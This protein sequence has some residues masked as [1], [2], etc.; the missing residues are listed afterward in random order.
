M[1]DTGCP[2]PRPPAI[3]ARQATPNPAV[4]RPVLRVQPQARPAKPRP[5]MRT[6]AC[7]LPVAK[8]GLQPALPALL[9]AEVPPLLEAFP[10]PWLA[11]AA[12]QEPLAFDPPGAGPAEARTFTAQS[13]APAPD[14]TPLIPTGGIAPWGGVLVPAPVPGIPEPSTWL[15]ALVGVAALAWKA[16]RP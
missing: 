13:A 1:I 7:S 6:T 16:R 14:W 2:P 11:L 3:I 5:R 12:P 4:Q 15:L 8:P 9:T 10:G